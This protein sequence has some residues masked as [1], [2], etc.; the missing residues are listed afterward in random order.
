MLYLPGQLQPST[1]C[2]LSNWGALGIMRSS[3]LNV[4]SETNHVSFALM[5]RLGKQVMSRKRAA[6]QSR[7]K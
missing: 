6:E 4:A 7:E 2:F 1:K 3:S 5:A